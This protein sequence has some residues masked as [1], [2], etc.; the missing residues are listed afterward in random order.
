MLKLFLFRLLIVFILISYLYESVATYYNYNKT[1]FSLT[2]QYSQEK[3]EA[4]E[5]FDFYE[6]HQ[7]LQSFICADQ[8]ISEVEHF[9]ICD[10]IPLNYSADI[11]YPPKL[12]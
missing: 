9:Y 3:E 11:F 7:H 8:F 5:S 12:A 10:S 1:L 4:K 2:S 6:E